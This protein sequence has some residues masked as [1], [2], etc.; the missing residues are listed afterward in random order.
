MN[1]EIIIEE[2]WYRDGKYGRDFFVK[3]FEEKTSGEKCILVPLNVDNPPEL[4]I[5]V[6]PP[7][8]QPTLWEKD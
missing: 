1:K 6:K 5:K 4:W 3:I 7:I 8:K 2:G